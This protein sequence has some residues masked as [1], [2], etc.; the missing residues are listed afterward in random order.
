MPSTLR[1][2]SSIKSMKNVYSIMSTNGDPE[3]FLGG[4]SPAKVEI[5]CSLPR[6]KDLTEPPVHN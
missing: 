5:H 3:G 1:F 6:F 2:H 4:P